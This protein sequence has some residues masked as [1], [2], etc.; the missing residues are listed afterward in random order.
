MYHECRHIMPNGGRCHW[1]ALRGTPLCYFHTRIHRAAKE[2]DHAYN[3]PLKLPLL[4]DRT[5]IQVALSQVLNALASAKVDARQAGL[6]LYGLQIA[7]QNVERD[8]DILQVTAVNSVTRTEDGDE[9]APDR[10]VCYSSE[11]DCST[12]PERKNCPN[13]GRLETYDEDDDEA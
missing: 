12:C 4:E 1:P 9:L 7:S 3:E 2:P 10:R 11:D 13:Y 6:F 8:V 5:A